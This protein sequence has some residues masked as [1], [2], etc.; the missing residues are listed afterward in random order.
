MIR[1]NPNPKH[2]STSFVE[3]ANLTM[4]M[5]MRRF[6]RLTNGFSKKLENHA[7]MVA[8]Y[9]VWYNWIRVHKTLRVTPAMQAG[10]AGRVFDMIDLV[11]LIEQA[12][13]PQPASLS[14]SDS[15]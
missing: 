1:G 11:A 2:I 14:E 3:R 6:T 10:L 12:E 15:A 8:L 7:H 5:H 9:A 13:A 4:R